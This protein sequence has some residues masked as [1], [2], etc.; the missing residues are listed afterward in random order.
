METSRDPDH[1]SGWSGYI[2]THRLLQMVPSP[3]WLAAPMNVEYTSLACGFNVCDFG[4]MEVSVDNPVRSEHRET[5]YCSFYKT[6]C[7]R[8]PP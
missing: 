5:H 3:G 8:L 2:D 6:K 7:E 4:L 1:P